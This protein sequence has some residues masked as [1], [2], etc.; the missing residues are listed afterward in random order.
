MKDGGRPRRQ[1][2]RCA[3]AHVGQTVFVNDT[4][5]MERLQSL[6]DVDDKGVLRASIDVAARGLG[7]R[8]PNEIVL[9]LGH[10]LPPML[11]EPLMA[12]SGQSPHS[13]ADLYERLS[14]RTGIPLDLAL[15]LV[16]CVFG[17]A[18]EAAQRETVDRARAQLPPEWGNLLYPIGTEP[19]GERAG[20]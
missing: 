18:G 9:D 12:G 11:A 2:R 16:Q 8:L 10:E 7:A 4:Q 3:D 15:S 1:R 14:E 5:L 17:L 6:T 13:P 19:H 20:L